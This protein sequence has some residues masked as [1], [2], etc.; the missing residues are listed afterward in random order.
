MIVDNFNILSVG[1]LPYET[2]PPLIV[3]SNT[4]L[5]CTI[6]L[7]SFQP[8]PGYAP[9]FLQ[10]GGGIENAELSASN[11]IEPLEPF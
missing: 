9:N 6:A 4:V 3:Y 5:L 11:A 7:E 1:V 8:V 10:A 2:D